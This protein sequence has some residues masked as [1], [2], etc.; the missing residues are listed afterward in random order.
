MGM[1]G[2]GAYLCKSQGDSHSTEPATDTGGRISS[3]AQQLVG[4]NVANMKDADQVEKDGGCSDRVKEI[5]VEL[6]VNK[7][8]GC[9]VCRDL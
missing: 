5:G 9:T 4:K 6:G 1:L 2:P 7:M 8:Y 3:P